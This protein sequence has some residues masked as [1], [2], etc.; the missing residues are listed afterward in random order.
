MAGVHA[1]RSGLSIFSFIV[2]VAMRF[3]FARQIKTPLVIL[4]KY[5]GERHYFLIWFTFECIPFYTPGL[6]LAA[7]GLWGFYNV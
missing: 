2:G 3:S 5:F 1:Y 6:G 4:K 7:Y